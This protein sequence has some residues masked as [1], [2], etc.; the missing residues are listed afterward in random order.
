MAEPADEVRSSIDWNAEIARHIERLQSMMRTSEDG[1]LS[2]GSELNAIHVTTRSISD[3]LATLLGDFSTQ[4]NNGSLMDLH[5]MSDRSTRQLRSFG[6]FSLRIVDQL[7][8]LKAPLSALP[9]L[10]TEFNRLVSRLRIMGITARMEAARMGVYGTGFVHL[11][12]EVS[13]LGQQIGT[14]AKEVISYIKEVIGTIETN[15]GKLKN[16]LREHKDIGERI[17]ADMRYNLALLDE[18]R[19]KSKQTTSEISGLSVNALRNI[20]VVV[21]SVQYHDITRQQVEHVIEALQSVQ[22]QDSVIEIVPVCQVQAAHLKRVAQEFE[23]AVLSIIT[24]LGDLSSAVTRMLS[25]SEQMTSFTKNSG[26]TFLN[27]VESSLEIVSSTMLEDQYAIEGLNSSLKEVTENIRKMKSFMDEMSFVGSEVGLLALN[28]RV[29]AARVGVNGSALGVIAESIQHLSI[30]AREQI[31]TVIKLMNHMV[32]VSAELA[33]LERIDAVTRQ[34]E[35]EIHDIINGLNGA[36]RVFHKDNDNSV[37]IFRETEQMCQS[38]VTQLELL[39]GEIGSHRQVAATLLGV[40]SDLEQLVGQLKAS[41]PDSARAII[42]E[43][44]HK[45][46]NRYTM[47][48]ERITHAAVLGENSAHTR[49]SSGGGSIELF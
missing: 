35:S 37:G 46:F 22:Q 1:F 27:H 40:S 7:Q 3:K 24:A 8:G 11:A 48:T 34:A 14:K 32:D 17:Y 41:V 10:L 12:E 5:T 33:D 13:S 19:E 18:K 49:T 30:E 39:S 31:D 16:V 38:I 15:E 23:N 4:G 44:V 36:I 42:D 25:E 6:D 45:M 2:V 28:S 26:K 29:K 47:E 9:E 20:H 43:R 21:Q